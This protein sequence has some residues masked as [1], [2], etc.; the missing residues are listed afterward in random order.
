MQDSTS[1]RWVAAASAVVASA[2]AAPAVAATLYG[3]TTQNSIVVFDSSA[4]SVSLD[5][6]FVMGLAPGEVL[7]AMD[8]RPATG[9]VYAVGSGDNLYTIAQ[10]PLGD[11]QA[12][13]VGNFAP[14]SNRG[15]SFAFDFNPAFMGGEFARLI[16]DT[17]NNRV[18]S[19][20]T[21]QY[22]LPVDKTPVFY[23]PGDPNEGA[24]PNIAGIA[25]TNSLPGATSTQ[26]F[27]I[28]ATL[29]VLTTVANNAG[30]LETVGSLGIMPLTNELGFDIDGPSG[31]AYAALQ[32]GSNSELYTIDLNTGAA[33]LVGTIASGDIIRDITAVPEPAT[34]VLLGLAGLGLVRR[35]A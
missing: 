9:Q 24:N 33:S 32:N 30:T 23:A 13:L 8:F 12:S 26:Q 6:G 10:T 19:G 35:R 21:G 5:G 31:V 11:F 28:D 4:P 27:G 2:V 15:T 25:Y 34:L 1:S 20:E 16:S 14:P 29:G 18:I 7:L 17:D 22:L 3:L